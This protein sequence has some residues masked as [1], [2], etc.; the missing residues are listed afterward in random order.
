MMTRAR[1]RDVDKARLVRDWSRQARA[2]DF[3]AKAVVSKAKRSAARTRS[4]LSQGDLFANPDFTAT[5]TAQWAV[6]HLSER[7][8]VFKHNELLTAV[9]ARDPGAATALRLPRVVLVGDEKQL[10]GVDAGKPFS[11]LRKA[12]MTTAVMG[13]ILR[14]RNE[15]LRKA[16]WEKAYYEACS[17]RNTRI[18]VGEEVEKFQLVTVVLRRI[19]RIS[20]RY[21]WRQPGPIPGPRE[22]PWEMRQ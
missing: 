8:S 12:G 9:L 22:I 20:V 5:Q 7:Q 18:S 11:Q 4:S 21:R 6:D 16:V 14:Q 2:V 3:S 19:E 10:D 15:K 13:E 1:K 17:P